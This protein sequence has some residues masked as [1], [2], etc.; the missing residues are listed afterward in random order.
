MD[1]LERGPLDLHR[2]LTAVNRLTRPARTVPNQL[3]DPD[4]WRISSP[5]EDSPSRNFSH[6]TDSWTRWKRYRT[7]FVAILIVVFRRPKTT[8]R[9]QVL[10]FDEIVIGAG[11]TA[12]GAVLGLPANRRV[13]VIG[14]PIAGQFVHYDGAKTK[15]SAYLGHGGLGTYWHGAIATGGQ[16]YFA[17]AS[18]EYFDRLVRRFYPNTQISERLGKP[19]L[20]VPWRPI[21]PKEEWRRMKAER[22]DRLVFVHEVVSR[23]V[24]GDRDVS[25]H[26]AGSTFVGKRLWVCAG[27]LHSPALL[28]DSLAAPVSRQFV[29][30]H[31]F[32]YLG[33]IDRA[34]T[35]VEMPRVLRTRDGVWFEGR[36]DDER[37]ARYTLRP[38]RFAFTRL[39]Y[40]IERRGIFGPPTGKSIAKIVRSISLGLFAEALYNHFGLF[41]NARV[42]SVYA[43][44]N[45]PDAHSFH[46]S[47]AQ[48]SARRDVI[49]TFVDA[50]RANPPWRGIQTSIRPD[51]FIPST[52]L[53]HSVDVGALVGAGVNGPTSRVQVV[54]AS[55][56]RDV[57]PD[58]HTFKLMVAAFHRAQALCQSE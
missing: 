28:D 58:H 17:G 24:A 18:A 2:N 8:E 22:S 6:V 9:G 40:G 23:F 33:Q 55:V 35:H 5:L 32:C 42:Q 11:L 43:L 3:G 19:W 34:R 38:A 49:Q 36:Y 7:C 20:F 1:L 4:V 52:H 21:R 53:H 46:S 15:V 51:I 31:V 54:D 26:T 45:V 30:D 10:I 27:A 39:D 47:D 25:V 12:L 14:G 44:I 16:Q 56:L 48:L 29:S 37:R 50:V 57:G 41:P 13:L